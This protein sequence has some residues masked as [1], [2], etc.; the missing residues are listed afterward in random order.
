[1]IEDQV[2]WSR[3]WTLVSELF[4]S[5]NFRSFTYL[6]LVPSQSFMLFDRVSESFLHV[7][8]S[9]GVEWKG[10]VV[11]STVAE[12]TWSPFDAEPISWEL[13]LVHWCSFWLVDAMV[14]KA[15]SKTAICVS[16]S[17]RSA[18][19]YV[20]IFAYIVFMLF[21]EVISTTCTSTTQAW[22]VLEWNSAT[23]KHAKDPCSRTRI[24][25]QIT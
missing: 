20:E 1:M 3:K 16:D 9:L 4:V 24:L 10:V 8:V 12:F 22:H 19:L 21:V 15:F 6:I 14:I 11:S 17:A 2:F 25:D 18:C 7:W 13:H 23:V 5:E